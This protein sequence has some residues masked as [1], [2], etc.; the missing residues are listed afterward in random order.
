MS[1]EKWSKFWGTQLISFDHTGHA[2]C[3]PDPARN[4]HR[5]LICMLLVQISVSD[6]YIAFSILFSLALHE[7]SGRKR[8]PEPRKLITFEANGNIVAKKTGKHR[9]LY[10]RLRWNSVLDDL[11]VNSKAMPWNRGSVYQLHRNVRSAAN[12]PGSRKCLRSAKGPPWLFI[13]PVY[14]KIIHT[15][16]TT[17]CN[18]ACKL[19]RRKMTGE[20]ST[21]LNH[22]PQ[23]SFHS[24]PSCVTLCGHLPSRW[25]IGR[26]A[27]S[28][29]PWRWLK[30]QATHVYLRLAQKILWSFC[31]T[32]IRT[33]YNLNRISKNHLRLSYKYHMGMNSTL[34]CSKQLLSFVR[35]PGSTFT[36]TTCLDNGTEKRRPSTAFHLEIS[37]CNFSLFESTWNTGSTFAILICYRGCRISVW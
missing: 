27:E 23:S 26:L 25:M 12:V 31:W 3:K 13:T 7:A 2:S 34:R 14:T 17:K 33:L 37:R 9:G 29:V 10:R 35:P 6:G 36:G 18:A 32:T 21:L 22:C 16:N 24:R 19:A 20:S 11:P 5:G 8:W 4:Q 30:Q 15:A 28:C 1:R